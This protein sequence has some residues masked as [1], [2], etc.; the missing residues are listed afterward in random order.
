MRVRLE[1]RE[2]TPVSVQIIL[3]LAAVAIALVL[4][5]GL[6]WLAGADVLE[7]Y[8]ILF[9]STFQSTY[10]LQ[11][12]LVKA[13]PLLFT[14]LAVV[15]AFRAKFWNIGAEGQ[16]M[17]GAI[18]AGFIGERMFLP[19]FALVPLMILGAAVCGALWALLPALL[20]VKLKVDDVV[21]TLLLNFIMLYGVTALLEGPW[22]D[23]KSGYPNS[24]SIRAEAEFPILAGYQMH[25]GIFLALIAAI[26]VWW[27]L[28]R[29][30]LGFRI[31]AVGHNP[32]ASNYGG[33][34][35][36]RVIVVAALISG[37]LAG[38]AGAGEVG[39]VRYQV[40]AD[41]TSG[42]GYAGIVIATL[43]ELNPLGAI[44]AALFFAV[45]FNGAGTMSRALGVPI[46]LADV[47]QGVALMTMVA[48]RLF[49]VYRLRVVRHA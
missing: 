34:P 43:A 39:G 42:Y 13:A 23:P 30:T 14:G 25:L 38:L 3:P 2:T 17:A 6:V 19:T 46:Y 26:L 7:A 33:I 28:A 8:S 21:S 1:R 37:A 16:L 18:A 10:D 9:L 24:P 15:V 11:D 20:K 48:M 27:M 22:R 49:A 4:C 32:A 41:L 47:I 40:T 5:S 36:G 29:T 31:R 45:I 12:T 35:V 44:P